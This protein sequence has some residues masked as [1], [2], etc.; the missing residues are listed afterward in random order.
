LVISAVR[1]HRTGGHSDRARAFPLDP[2]SGVRHSRPVALLGA[3][4]A[5]HSSIRASDADRDAVAERL[6]QAAVEG[7]LEPDELEERLHAALRARTYGE[8]DGLLADLPS[9]RP[10]RRR[11][12]V[13]PAARI[14]LAVAVRIALLLAIVTVVVAVAALTAAWWLLWALVWLT[15]RAGRGSC[16]SRQPAWRRPARARR[17]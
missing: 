6:R 8:L 9:D 15:L 17:V 7:R 16:S 14:A 2:C 13:V 11:T 4:W 3:R 12:D 10:A 5:R 1:S